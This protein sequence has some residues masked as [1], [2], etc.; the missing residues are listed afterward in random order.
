MSFISK[1]LSRICRRAPLRPRVYSNP[2]F[3]RIPPEQ[4]VE[5]ETLPDY[6]PARY[7]P[8]Q[9]GEVFADRYQVVGKLGFG[10][11][12]TV[13][14]A[15]DLSQDDHVTLKVFIRSQALVNGPDGEHLVLAHPPLGDSLE[16]GIRR[17]SPRRLPPSGLRY[18][19]KDIFL[20]LDYLHVE[21]QI[22]HT[23]IKAD[24]IMFRITDP[25]ILTDFAEQEL[26]APCPRKELEGRTI[27]TSRA[28]KS[29]GRIGPPVL[30]DF[31]AA[32]FADRENIACVQP[33]VYRAPEVILKCHWDHKIDIW[34][35]GCMAWNL[36]EGDLLFHAID[37]EH[38]EYRRRAHL[39]EIIGVLGLPPKDLLSRGQLTNKFFSDQGTYIGGIQLPPPTPL[40]ELEALLSG[41][42]RRQFL[43]FM[44][45]ML[46]WAPEQRSTANELWCDDWLQENK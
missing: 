7:Y 35:V 22:I 21:C 9:I 4:K 19:L 13:W 11:T 44:R 3:I 15:H 46:Q 5:E 36:F 1:V 42:E 2:N 38:L 43:E 37:P 41:D 34:N 39:A 33:H 16:V 6:L 17:S 27:Y 40:E 24:N 29:T 12:S 18:I 28:F 14:L 45:K 26:Q 20:A 23:D 31:G 10:A 8:V 25:S 30:C 32:V